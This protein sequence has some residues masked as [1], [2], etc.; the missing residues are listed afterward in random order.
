MFPFHEACY[1]VLARA[2]HN[3]PDTTRIDKDALYTTMIEQDYNY[4][5]LQSLWLDYGHFDW[6]EQTWPFSAGYEVCSFLFYYCAMHVI[7]QS[8][9]SELISD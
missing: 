2:L 1:I 3:D 4:C 8:K 9:S 5:F 7:D 6:K